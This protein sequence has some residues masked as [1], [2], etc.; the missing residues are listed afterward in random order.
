MSA[1]NV[2]RAAALAIFFAAACIA[3]T[4]PFASVAVLLGIL[5]I[6]GLVIWKPA[7]FF[8]M[9]PVIVPAMDLTPWTGRW[10]VNEFDAW[11]LAAM[12]AAMWGSKFT[13]KKMPPRLELL[14]L[15]I[16]AVSYLASVV[17]AFGNAFSEQSEFGNVYEHPLNAIRIAKPIVYGAFFWILLAHSNIPRNSAF[18]MFGWGNL[19]GLGITVLIV[20]IERE[21]FCGLLSTIDV[22]RVTGPFAEMH[23]GGAYL[24]AYL[25]TSIPLIAV[26]W[27]DSNNL[28]LRVILILLLLGSIYAVLATLSRAPVIILV[29]QAVLF[30]SLSIWSAQRFKWQFSRLGIGVLVVAICMSAATTFTPLRARFETI[31]SDWNSRVE[32]WGACLETMD[33]SIQTRVLG[34]GCGALPRKIREQT[35]G[36]N[37]RFDVDR[38]VSILRLTGSDP[39][40]FGQ[41]LPI[42]PNTNYK[43]IVTGRRMNDGFG[44]HVS[45]CEKN[46]LY[47]FASVGKSDFLADLPIGETFVSSTSL[48]S[49]TV[50]DLTEGSLLP[51]SSRPTVI[52]FWTSAGTV[53][54]VDR[55]QLLDPNG[56]DL[57]NNGSFEQGHDRW[58]WTSDNHLSWHAKNLYLHLLIEQGWLGLVAFIAVSLRALFLLVWRGRGRYNFVPIACSIISF[59]LIG[60]IDSVVDSPRLTLFYLMLLAFAF[61]DN[62]ENGRSH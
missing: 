7:V 26:F 19:V 47:S 4:L 29:I 61:V 21:R 41:Y 53:V 28:K 58:G 31:A 56:I 25:V 46:L 43:L 34:I 22:F 2:K 10:Y 42:Q 36:G 51:N 30:A 60:V 1:S 48:F 6:A 40:Y 57:V 5:L 59:L 13:F 14:L 23:T 8:L 15:A 12:A 24:D 27:T 11:I 54:D 38:G 37:Y 39:I 55:V 17:V 18:R 49:G 3:V 44:F 52:S 9:I 33:G 50:G 20:A 16:L 62:S 45:I 35:N 32:H